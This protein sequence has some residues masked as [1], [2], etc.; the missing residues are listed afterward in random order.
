MNAAIQAIV[1]IGATRGYDVFGVERGYDGLIDGQVR[2]L[3]RHLG[4]LVIPESGVDG[5]GALGGT[6][7]GSSR[8]P[9]FLD[10]VHRAKA[11]ANL[12][13]WGSAGLIVIG[14]NGSI[15]GAHALAMECDIPVVGI[16]A[17]IDNDIGLTR[18]SIGVDTALNTIVE[19][20]DRISDTAR[21]HH[22]AFIVEVMGRDSGYLAMASAVATAADAVL[23]PEQSRSYDQVI[24]NVASCIRHSFSEVRGKNRVLIIKAE[25]V[26]IPMHLL[27]DAVSAEVEDMDVDVRGTVLGHLVRGGNS[28]FR[29]RLIAG[30]FGLVAVDVILSGRTDIMVGWNLTDMGESTSDNFVRIFPMADVIA[31][32]EA[33]LDG[34]SSVSQDRVVRMAKIQGVLAL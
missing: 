19:A 13:D 15:A 1:K 17:S 22:R 10:P 7:L 31:E 21:S 32:S 28:S 18:E 3:T 12:A 11:A 23:L 14:G 4:D 24:E 25:G 8:S 5:I 6:V 29:D 16:P 2:S 26:D 20:C 34:T 9:R 33:L 30:R 27:V